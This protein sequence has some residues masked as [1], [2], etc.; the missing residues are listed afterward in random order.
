MLSSRTWPKILFAGWCLTSLALLVFAIGAPRFDRS[1][2]LHTLGLG[3]FSAAISVPIG[4]LLAWTCW[5][6]RWLNRVMLLTTSALLAVPVFLHVS[7][8]DA[9]FGRLGWLASSRGFV[10][11]PLVSG[12][13]AACWIHGLAAAPQVATIL[14]I[15]MSFCRQTAEE[16]AL[17]DMSRTKVFWHVRL[18]RLMPLF[19]LSTLWTIV[20]TSREIAATDLYR[21][22]TLA[23]QI[24]LGY[25]LGQFNAG[26]GGWSPD[27]LLAA[28]Q[29]NY[30][31]TLILIGW[32]A[33]TTGLLCSRWFGQE[34]EAEFSGSKIS[35]FQ[36]DVLESTAS[37]YRKTCC[38]FWLLL[39]LLGIPL[40]NLVIRGC[41]QIDQIDGQPVPSY[42]MAQL[43][44]VLQRSLFNYTS[45]FWWSFLIG[46]VS[47]SLIM[48]VGIIL[49]WAARHSHLS[50]LFMTL[51]WVVSCTIPGPLVGTLVNSLFQ[52][53]DSMPARYLYDRTIAAPVLA[54]LIFCW[55]FPPLLIWFIFRNTALD[56]IENARLEGAGKWTRFWRFGVLDHMP[57]LLGCWLVTL[58][59]CL[60]DLS[61]SQLVLPPGMD[62]LPRLMLGL[63]H[64]GVDELTAGIT[65]VMLSAIGLISV[66]GWTMIQWSF[67]GAGNG[68][69]SVGPI[70]R[71]IREY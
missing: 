46:T 37:R 36:T 49:V 29:L 64:S 42:S 33:A 16:Q 6:N 17:L 65:I 43:G 14:W 19:V 38:S 44:T 26:A 71:E 66:V 57:K 35:L 53:I 27:E 39:L 8:W 24:Y 41:F 20:V 56:V 7:M 45:E 61:A 34:V 40:I 30:G 13:L 3:L 2:A 48:T 31:L 18:R 23:E 55:P 22:G 21:I 50:R 10:L 62:T 70:P 32:L 11:Q 12:W 68:D 54:N 15:G 52:S 1:I 9:A 60:G 51:T 5:G 63:L 47:S 58:A 25:S 4:A 59:I 28:S 67:R 69:E